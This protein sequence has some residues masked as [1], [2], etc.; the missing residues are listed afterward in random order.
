MGGRSESDASGQ[1][2]LDRFLCELGTGTRSQAKDMVKSGRVRVNGETA[3][4]ADVKISPGRDEVTLDG[5]AL[6]WEET[7][8]YMLNKPAGVLSASTDPK[9]ETVVSLVPGGRKDIFPVGRLDAD[10][11][12]LLLITNDGELAHRLLSPKRHCAK[13]YHVVT[14]L[15]I[16]EDAGSLFARGI[17]L[18]DFVSMPADWEPERENTGFLTLHEGKFHQVKRM[19]ASMGLTVTALK[20]VSFAGIPLD[21]GLGPGE[22]RPLDAG[23]IAQL[24]KAGGLTEQ[25]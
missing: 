2:R 24:K 15:P 8:W 19:F 23:E 1:M 3:R 22:C 12:G 13:V 20:R 9:R 5:Q 25:E 11:T 10:T 4:K 16:P 7:V 6:V 21:T 17:D 14:D 18:G